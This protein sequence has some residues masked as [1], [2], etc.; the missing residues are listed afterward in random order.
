MQIEGKFK[1]LNDVI[2]RGTFKSR[3]VWIT[4]ED[5]PQYPQTIEIELQG[6][7]CLLFDNIAVGAPVTCHVNLRGREWTNADGETKCFNSL[8]CWRVDGLKS[9][10]VAAPVAKSTVAPSPVDNS[11]PF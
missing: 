8:V 10:P 2:E 9:E 7:K 4:T 11:L 6:D 3:K 5:N 1:Q